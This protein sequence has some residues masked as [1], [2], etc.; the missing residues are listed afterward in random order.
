MRAPF[1]SFLALIA[2]GFS[3]LGFTCG[4]DY[5]EP[6]P[7]YKFAEKLTLTP[8]QKEYAVND[9]IWVGFQTADRTLFDQLSNARIATDT[10]SLMLNISYSRSYPVFGP[11]GLLC[12]VKLLNGVDFALTQQYD[13]HTL[14]RFATDCANQRYFFRVGFIP[15][16]TGTYSINPQAYLNKCA[17]KQAEPHT[18]FRLTFDLADCNK[19]V[20]LAIPPAS[21]SGQLGYTDMAIE[22]KELFFFRV[23]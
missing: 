1:I 10:S 22:R 3:T 5:A 11:P 21:R 13:Y 6:V 16:Q 7:T 17:S 4:R 18:E 8:Y 15:K 12:E 9:T 20:F 2:L 19:E 23:K 14:L